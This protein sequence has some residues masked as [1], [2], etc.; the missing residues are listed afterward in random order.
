M[1]ELAHFPVFPHI[2]RPPTGLRLLLGSKLKPITISMKEI[3]KLPKV[4]LTE[5]FKCLEGWMV[6]DVLWEGVSL[7]SILGDC[8]KKLNHPVPFFL[9]GSGDFTTQ[10]SRQKAFKRTTILATKMRDR[11][12]TPAHGGPLRLVFESH[13]CYESIKSVDRIMMLEKPVNTTARDI[14]TSRIRKGDEEPSAQHLL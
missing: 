1:E 12:L 4:K 13:K 6:K 10:L 14:A 8:E 11:K 3:E 9:I 2:K 7:S 5:D